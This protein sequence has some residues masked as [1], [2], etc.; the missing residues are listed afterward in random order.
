MAEI[1]L[2][3]IQSRLKQFGYNVQSTDTAAIK[4]CMD[5]ALSEIKSSIAQSEIPDEMTNATIDMAVGFFL[6]QKKMWNTASFADLIDLDGAVAS[7][8]EGDTSVSFNNSG[9]KT[10]EQRL[11]EF[12]AFLLSE[13]SAMYSSFRKLRW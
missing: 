5:S 9:S 13:A 2:E 4:Y 6:Q 10:D 1:T 3:S 11:D 12:I 8:S 7:I